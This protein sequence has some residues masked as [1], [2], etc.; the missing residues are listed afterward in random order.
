MSFSC[1]SIHFGITTATVHYRAFQV[2]PLTAET[3][4]LIDLAAFKKMKTTAIVVNI[5]RGPVINTDDMVTALRTGEIDSVGLDVG[6]PHEHA[7]PRRFHTHANLP[8]ARAIRV[9]GITYEPK[10]N[11][12]NIFLPPGVG[13]NPHPKKTQPL[14]EPPAVASLG[15]CL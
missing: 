15:T 1:S 3:T 11:K 10:K 8:W 12:K 9:P 4:G 5:S 7:F 14:P 6:W 2:C 13:P